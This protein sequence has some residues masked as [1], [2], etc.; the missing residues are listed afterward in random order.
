MTKIEGIKK[1]NLEKSIIK[2]LVFFDLFNQPLSL[3]EI[4]KYLNIK[5]NLFDIFACLKNMGSGVKSKNGFYCLQDR[6]ELIIERFKK[7]NYFKRKIKRA[8]FF[9]KLISF[10]PFVRGVAVSNVIADHNLRDESDI[11]LFI[12]SSK[13]RI[14]LT[15]FFCTSLAKLLSLRPNKKTKK[16]KICLSFYVSENNLNLE[17]YLYNEDDYYFIYW[18]AGLEVLVNKNGVFE[19]FFLENS[20]VKRYLPNFSFFAASAPVFCS[21]ATKDGKTGAQS[22]ASPDSGFCEND[23]SGGGCLENFFKKIQ[24][25]IMPKDLKNKNSDFGGVVLRDNIIKLFLDDKR[26]EF[27]SKFKERLNKYI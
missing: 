24:L 9:S 13:N 1:E 22:F 12:I 7:Y 2:T 3:F 4:Y 27:I 10:F 11:D 8:I 23:N 6:E 18:I 19:N 17:K 5:S 21:G 15:R 14:W 25:K 16:D 26:P 20:W